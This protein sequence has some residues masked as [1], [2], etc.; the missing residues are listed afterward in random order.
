[1]VGWPCETPLRHLQ[2]AGQTRLQ[3][4]QIYLFFSCYWT[5]L[6]HTNTG[7]SW[8]WHWPTTWSWSSSRQC[9]SRST[10][11][12]SGGT[13]WSWSWSS[14]C[15]L[16][17]ICLK[18]MNHLY[19]ILGITSST[20]AGWDLNL[21]LAS[22]G[23]NNTTAIYRDSLGSARTFLITGDLRLGTVTILTLA[24][25]ITLAFLLTKWNGHCCTIGG[26][27]QGGYNVLYMAQIYFTP[28]T[29]LPNG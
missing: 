6:H 13:S 21:P 23:I 28:P 18:M 12:P 14:T 1:M 5:I 25:N 27:L 26:T 4:S 17:W 24:I 3:F 7:T 22:L 8:H 16:L 10:S 9:G 2:W 29:H 15:W 11:W 20:G 19:R